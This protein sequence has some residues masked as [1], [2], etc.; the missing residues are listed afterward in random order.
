MIEKGNFDSHHSS[1]KGIRPSLSPKGNKNFFA[2]PNLFGPWAGPGAPK[3][4]F[5]FFWTYSSSRPTLVFGSSEWL[6]P[7]SYMANE[8]KRHFL[9]FSINRVLLTLCALYRT[10]TV[11]AHSMYG[12][13]DA[14]CNYLHIGLKYVLLILSRSGTLPINC[15]F[16][17]VVPF[18]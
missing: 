7:S 4:F 18:I 11:L 13:L 8:R 10:C 15:T 14:R 17:A 3:N 6:V 5:C 1:P 16:V 12:A 9:T 2:F